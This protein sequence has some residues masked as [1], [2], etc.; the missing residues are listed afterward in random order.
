MIKNIEVLVAKPFFQACWHGN[1][2]ISDYPFCNGL[3]QRRSGPL[4][5]ADDI[6]DPPLD[7]QIRIGTGIQQDWTR[8]V[9]VGVA[10]EFIDP[11]KARINQQGGPL[12]GDLQGEYGTNEAHIFAVNLIWKF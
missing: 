1:W 11:D 4:D 10:Y 9:T 2:T 12:Q 5:H 6:I 3:A 7:R 8:N